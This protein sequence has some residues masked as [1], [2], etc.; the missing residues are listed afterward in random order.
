MPLALPPTL[1]RAMHYALR[2]F[3][4][5]A[6]VSALTLVAAAV[7]QVLAPDQVNWVVWL[8]A[9]AYTAG[10]LWLVTLVR[11]VRR[12]ADRSAFTRV[13]IVSVLAPIGILALVVAPDSGYPVWMKVEQ[14]FFGVLLLP[15]GLALLRP[16]M[17]R[18]LL[19]AQ[20]GESVQAA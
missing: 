9:A 14:A 5:L 17:K 18:A 4:V 15:L 3:T 13:R 6:A 12:S 16:S 1:D 10:G 19:A 8:R 7:L 11:A 2:V 20:Q